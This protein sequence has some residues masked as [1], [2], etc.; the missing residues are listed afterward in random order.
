LKGLGAVVIVRVVSGTAGNAAKI[1]EPNPEK[2]AFVEKAGDDAWAFHEVRAELLEAL[3]P[4]YKT[5]DEQEKAAAKSMLTPPVRPIGRG[6]DRTP[7]SGAPQPR[8]ETKKPVRLEQENTIPSVFQKRRKGSQAV[9]CIGASSSK[10][11]R[12]FQS[13]RILVEWWVEAQATFLWYPATVNRRGDGQ[14]VIEYDDRDTEEVKEDE[15]DSKDG[16]PQFRVISGDAETRN[17]IRKW[18]P[19]FLWDHEVSLG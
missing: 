5:L 3:K 19:L 6:T 11:K 15:A 10:R 2:C 12:P 18:R 8:R 14:L 13:K 1:L 9:T 16:L 4:I 7:P 17:L